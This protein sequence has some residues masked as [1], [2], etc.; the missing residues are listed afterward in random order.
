MADIQGWLTELTRNYGWSLLLLLVAGVIWQALMISSRDH[1]ERRFR[2][3][4]LVAILLLL[5][6]VGL[7]LTW[8][9]TSDTRTQ[10]LTLLGLMVTAVL[11]LS[12]PT[13]AANAMAGF[14]LRSL[15]KFSP[16]DFIQ[17]EFWPDHRTGPV[18]HRNPDRRPGSVDPAQPLSVQSPHQSGA[19]RRHGGVG[20]SYAWLRH[21][22]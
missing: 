2:D 20:G 4:L 9:L 7:V 3:Q 6:A 21:R 13:I 22:P 16:G 12:S 5:T 18:P 14:M 1:R 8:P 15:K 17:V 11:T 10:L 19:R